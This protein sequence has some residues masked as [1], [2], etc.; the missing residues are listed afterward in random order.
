[1]T[2]DFESERAEI[3]ARFC[4]QFRRAFHHYADNIPRPDDAMEWLSLMQHHGAPTRLLDF[5]WSPY[6]AAFFALYRATADAAVWAF[7]PAQIS[8]PEAVERQTEA[9]LRRKPFAPRALRD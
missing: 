7:N 3:E 4:R 6:V 8:R 2:D 9:L 5:T 1:M